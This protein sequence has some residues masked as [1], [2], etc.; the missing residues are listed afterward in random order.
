M[1]EIADKDFKAAILN[2]S[3]YLNKKME[4]TV[5][6]YEKYENLSYLQGKT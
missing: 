1:L 4:N 6:S 2:I 3:K 5:E